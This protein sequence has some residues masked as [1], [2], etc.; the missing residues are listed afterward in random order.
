MDQNICHFVPYHKDHY[1][2]HTVNF[3]RETV[4][5]PK[6]DATEAM[7]RLHLVAAGTGTLQMGRQ[8][9]TLQPGD[10]FFLFPAAAYTL[11]PGEDFR[12]LY[13]SFLG[14]RANMIMEKLKVSRRNNVFSGFSELLPMWES[15]MTAAPAVIDLMSE[16]I[17]LHTFAALGQR[18][19]EIRRGQ[20]RGGAAGHAVKKYV[21]DH[22]MEQELSLDAISRALSYHKKYISTVFREAC[23][24]SLTEYLTT[25]RIQNACTLME[26]GVTSVGEI[27]ARCGFADSQYFSRVFKARMGVSPSAYRKEKT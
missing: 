24:V 16:S 22:F 8:T 19:P 7:Y 20:K 17:L 25:V 6:I 15:G 11:Q 18:L 9:Y 27:A 12:Y 21:D 23:G 2:I 3:V 1:S 4:P 14:A 10:L 13:I 26:D 5:R